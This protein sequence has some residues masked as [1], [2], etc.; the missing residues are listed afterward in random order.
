MGN[1]TLTI[2]D[3]KEVG[4]STWNGAGAIEKTYPVLWMSKLIERKPL[5][6]IHIQ[7]NLQNQRLEIEDAIKGLTLIF[8]ECNSKKKLAKAI[9]TLNAILSDENN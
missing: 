9:E 5:R 7:Y 8:E 1:S 6:M 2:E 4:F 3:F